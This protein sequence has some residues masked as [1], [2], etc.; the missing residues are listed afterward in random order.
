MVIVPTSHW[1]VAVEG[2][3]HHEIKVL[4]DITGSEHRPFTSVPEFNN[5]CLTHFM[6][7]ATEQKATLNMTPGN[8]DT[9]NKNE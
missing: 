5:S 3:H 4:V 6:H 2:R 1:I 8:L 9:T 7:S